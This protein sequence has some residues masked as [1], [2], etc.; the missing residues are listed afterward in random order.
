MARIGFGLA[1]SHGPMLS[2]PWENWTERV[3]AD[4]ANPHHF[5]QGKTY[6]FDEM[7]GVAQAAKPGRSADSG[8]VSANGTGDARKQFA[9]L[10]ISL[11]NPGRTSRWWSGTTRWRSSPATMCPAF[12]VFWGPYVEGIPRTP[13]FLASLPPGVARAELDRTPSV[14]TQYPTLPGLGS[15]IIQK[16]DG[17]RFR[18][19]AINAASHRRDRL[20]RRAARVWIRLPAFDARSSDSARARVREYVL[21]AESTDR[22][23][24]LRVRPRAGTRHRFVAG[25]YQCRRNRVR[26]HDA[27]CDRRGFRRQGS[28]RHAGG[29]RGRRSRVCPKR[30]FN[31]ARR[32]SRTGSRSPE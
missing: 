32:K 16:V 7:V 24:M 4:R 30:C 13:E 31:R 27:L 18:C 11:W 2:V 14:Y 20:Q 22:G 10:A 21:S 23:P 15:H 8:G 17:G 28:G 5:Y 26:R 6:T 3:A 9:N 29:R 1:T 12:A 25:R 19:G